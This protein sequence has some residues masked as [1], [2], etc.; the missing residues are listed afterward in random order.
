MR[1]KFVEVT[2]G[3][4][5]WGKFCVARMDDE[6]WQRRS[7]VAPYEASLVAGRGWTPDHVLVL[8][9]QTG[10]GAIF[11]P[12]GNAKADLEKHRVW[13]CPMFE[14]F[15]EWLYQQPDPMDIPDHVDLPDA[16]FEFRGH[17]RPG[18]EEAAS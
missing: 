11:K 12:G 18:P 2:N 5:N 4:R 15:L 1:T 8:D 3:P 16:Q 6:E 14:P 9:L 17:R 10:E 7:A 13:V